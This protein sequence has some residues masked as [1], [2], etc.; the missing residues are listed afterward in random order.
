MKKMLMMAA[1]AI[2][3]MTSCS[4]DSNSN[5]TDDNGN[6]DNTLLKKEIVNF[7]SGDGW[8]ATYSYY[9]NKLNTID[10]GDGEYDKATY[11]GNNIT[12]YEIFGAGY[13]LR[14]VIFEYDSNN[15]LIKTSERSYNNWGTEP[16]IET[17][18]MRQFTYETD[19]IIN[20]QEYM[21]VTPV[22]GW[23]GSFTFQNGNLVRIVRGDSEQLTVFDS[24]NSPYKNIL[25]MDKLAMVDLA[26]G[27]KNNLISYSYG[28]TSSV[29]NTNTTTYTYNENNYPVTG[30][31]VGY[32]AK[33]TQY[34]YE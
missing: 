17:I 29:P 18:R 15:R 30:T 14:D 21:G 27:P 25:G 13:L 31:T 23:T 12:K 32:H 3:T 24:K 22:A 33:T 19:N 9:G 10:Y 34:F 11:N 2:F 5:S 28:Y 1:V 20:F 4:D 7:E 6:T 26:D 8:T 16:T